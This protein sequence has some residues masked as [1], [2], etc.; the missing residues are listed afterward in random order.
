MKLPRKAGGDRIAA[1]KG[2]TL[3]ELLIVI[4]IIAVLAVLSFLGASKFKSKARGVTCASNLRQ[5]GTAMLAYAADNNGQLP[6]LEDRTGSGDS[7]KGIWPVIVSD[8]GYLE[9]VTNKNGQVGTGAGVWACPD[10][11]IVQRNYNGYGAAEGTVLKVKKG[12]VPG[13]SSPRIA[14]IPN[15]SRTWLVGDAAN[16]ANNLKSGWYAIWANPAQWSNSHTPAARH[17]G[18]VNVVMVDGHLESLTMTELRAK[19]YTMR[20]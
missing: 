20:N 14:S 9:K 13:S 11:T 6:P 3:V 12:S 1:E 15:P 2:F 16:Q 7:L 10:C 5:I 8:N 4:A 19:D 17:G 18:K